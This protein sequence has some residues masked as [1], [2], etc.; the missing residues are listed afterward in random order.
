MSDGGLRAWLE[1]IWYQG[2]RIPWSLRLLAGLYGMALRIK[3]LALRCGWPSVVQLATPVIVVGNLSVGG[4]GKTPLTIWLAQC[5]AR[6]GLKPGVVLRGYGGRIRGVHRVE[7]GDA[8]LEV[9]DEALLIHRLAR[10]PVVIGAD[11][12][13]AA[14][15]LEALGVRCILSDDGLQ[16][17]RL[18]RQLEIVVI[19]GQRGLGNGR[20]LPAGPLR[21]LPERA[22]EV[23]AI[24]ING[25]GPARWPPVVEESWRRSGAVNMQLLGQELHPVG[26]LLA[27]RPA[28][29]LRDLGGTTV[30]AVAGIGNPARFFASL[31]DAGLTVI[32]HAFP[33]HHRYR[34]SELLFGDA[35]AVLMTEKDAVKCAAFALPNHWALPVAAQFGPD[36]ARR[37]LERLFMD[38]R[39]LDL[40]VCPLCKGPLHYDKSQ[41]VLVCRAERLAYPIRD[42][43]PVM[44]EDEARSL[45]SDDPLLRT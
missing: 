37:L 35:V 18:G 1:R 45:P 43:M 22:A 11:R 25:H 39:L 19:D 40:L 28:V 21:E 20:L 15:R 26:T 8:A 29:A 32:E 5:M 38:K 6:H 31:R 44:L 3:G 42:G 2:H 13:A 33:D 14:R 17:R 41:A 27:A 23:D 34:E 30:H 16:H 36:A 4:T 10:C 24:V 12:V 9:G 7:S